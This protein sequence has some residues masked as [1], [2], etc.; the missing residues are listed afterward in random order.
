MCVIL[1]CP[2]NVR[3]DRETLDA[4][5]KA[6]P[7]GA[8]VAWRDG[9]RVRWSKGLEPDGLEPL[10]GT[11]PGEIVIHFRWASVGE[12]TPKLCHQIGRAHV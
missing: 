10:I 2:A 6:N 12:V 11:L 8:G 3:P 1:V 4:C 9:D 5:H 7:H